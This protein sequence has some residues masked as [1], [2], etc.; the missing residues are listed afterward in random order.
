MNNHRFYVIM[1][2]ISYISAM[3]TTQS[4]IIQAMFAFM[5]VVYGVLALFNKDQP[6]QKDE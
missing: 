1:C 6:K 4:D 5:S 2:G 3:E